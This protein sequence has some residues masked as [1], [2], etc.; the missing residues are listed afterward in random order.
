MPIVK[1]IKIKMSDAYTG[2]LFPLEIERQFE[3]IHNIEKETLYVNIPAGIDDNEIIVL[4]NKGHV[5]NEDIKGDL[6]VVIQIEND[7]PFIRSGMDLIYKKTISL[8][9]SLCGFSFEYNI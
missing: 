9:E 8:K 1:N 4:K 3:Q 2:I 6:K 5:I 7:S